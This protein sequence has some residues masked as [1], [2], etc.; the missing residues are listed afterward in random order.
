[1]TIL[2]TGGAGFIGSSLIRSLSDQ[3]HSVRAIDDLSSG[4]ESNLDG[5]TAELVVGSILDEVALRSALTG[6]TSIVHLAARGSVPR[7][8]AD[9]MGTHAANTEGTLAVLEAAREIGAHVVYS[10]SSSV[11]GV[12]TTLPKR[13]E[14]WAQPMSPYGASKLAAE[15]YCVA[16]RQVYDM[17]V[18]AFR[19][20][21]VYGPL[22]RADHDYAAVIPKFVWAAMQDET[23]MIHGDGEQTRDFTHV[24][25]VVSIL[26]DALQRR[27]S[28]D[29][30]VNL[31]FGDRVTVNGIAQEVQRQVGKT[32]QVM[33]TEARVGDV[34]DS[35]N[36]PT[37][38]LSLFPESAK[39]V[40][41]R[42]GVTSV[43]DWMHE[44]SRTG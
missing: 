25:S 1:M 41:F 30:P 13:E 8:V 24:D 39:A 40:D 23:L 20:F 11:Y 7:S 17:D 28:H 22:Q 32:A 21:N 43:I 19:F 5:T 38:L 3:G 29:R 35:R 2:V 12:N 37:L 18:L 31:A 4:L 14:M 26:T 33:H 27:V 10:S 6:V 15:S 34:R 16:Y 44:S 9:P 42:E 36:D